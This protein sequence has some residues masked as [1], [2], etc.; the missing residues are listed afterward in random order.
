MQPFKWTPTILGLAIV[1]LLLGANSPHDEKTGA[2]NYAR[3]L[4]QVDTVTTQIDA[5][6]TECLTAAGGGSTCELYGFG[7]VTVVKPT[8]VGTCCFSQRRT[9]VTLGA[10]S[11]ETE[12]QITANGVTTDCAG[13]SF[14]A[15]ESH[16]LIPVLE[17]LQKKG[18]TTYV[19]RY[20]KKPLPGAGGDQVYAPCGYG[21]TEN[22]NDTECNTVTGSSGASQCL[23]KGSAENTQIEVDKKG[24]ARVFCQPANNA[25]RFRAATER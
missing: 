11:A 22:D 21:A 23:A 7:S 2:I 10:Q 1:T 14:A 4:G 20:C 15:N 5:A 16:D 8:D 13:Y 3:S 25:T 19:G 17:N 12:G 18:P 24:S 6:N 9:G